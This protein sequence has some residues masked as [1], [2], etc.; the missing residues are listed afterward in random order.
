M[1]ST[2]ISIGIII[3]IA[4]GRGIRGVA[5]G[6]T[7]DVGLLAVVKEA[8]LIRAP[9]HCPAEAHRVEFTDSTVEAVVPNGP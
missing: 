1:S 7:V 8:K 5:T 2:L 3:T 4:T 6:A 9:V